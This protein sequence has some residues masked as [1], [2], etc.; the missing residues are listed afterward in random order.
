MNY[1]KAGWRVCLK[2]C[3]G[4]TAI[5]YSDFYKMQ[6]SKLHFF[7][8]AWKDS[9]DPFFIGK[10]LNMLKVEIIVQQTSPCLAPKAFDDSLL[11][12]F[13]LTPC[14]SSLSTLLPTC[15]HCF[16]CC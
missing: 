13:Y 14:P 11:Y 2:A 6:P 5:P 9:F 7:V 10:I 3:V 8:F 15:T 1:L 16:F 12:L 4:F